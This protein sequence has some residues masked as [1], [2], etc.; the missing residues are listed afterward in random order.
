[1]SIKI[2]VIDDEIERFKRLK[3]LLAAERYQHEPFELRVAHD[4]E[5][6]L[7]LLDQFQPEVILLD[8]HMPLSHLDGWAT[9]LH[10]RRRPGYE[11]GKRG[12]IMFSEVRRDL[13]D[14][15]TGYYAGTDRYLVTP[16]DDGQL[17]R[18]VKELLHKLRFRSQ[19]STPNQATQ[20]DIQSTNWVDEEDLDEREVFDEH[21]TIYWNRHRVSINGEEVRLQHLEYKLLK[22]LRN[23]LNRLCS[24]Q[25]LMLYAF[26]NITWSDIDN[27]KI[28]E[29]QL[30]SIYMPSMESLHKAISTLRKKL[31]NDDYQY[32][33]TQ[34]RVGYMLERKR[35]AT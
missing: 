22:Y 26:S 35:H 31:K 6:G 4:S 18:E 2:L 34:S 32:I 9:C 27:K 11:F 20:A 17:I 19:P 30:Q 13:V 7:A 12:V 15:D 5:T 8:I 24:Y 21:L 10:I 29:E 28:S 25:D 14:I 33:K 16:F 3:D 1:M 23:H